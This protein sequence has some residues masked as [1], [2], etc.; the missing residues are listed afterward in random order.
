MSMEVKYILHLHIASESYSSK[1]REIIKTLHVYR[2][3]G[4]T[5]NNYQVS[6]MLMPFWEWGDQVDSVQW[7]KS[8]R[9]QKGLICGIEYIPFASLDALIECLLN[10]GDCDI[11]E[12]HRA[13]NK[14]ICLI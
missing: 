9:L 10:L 6:R 12:R 7:L 11:S 3:E 2:V 13:I 5:R 8:K 4:S 1:R 14:L